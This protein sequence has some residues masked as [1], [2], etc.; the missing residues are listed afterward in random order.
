MEMYKIRWKKAWTP[1][2]EYQTNGIEV[3]AK[4]IYFSSKIL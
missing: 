2:I 1:H 3:F 4:R